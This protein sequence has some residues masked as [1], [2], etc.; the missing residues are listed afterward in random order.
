MDKSRPTTP[1]MLDDLA[2]RTS[3]LAQAQALAAAADRLRTPS[4][5]L[6][7]TRMSMP[8]LRN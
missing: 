2:A 6:G 5:A 3:S 4:A 7:R 1:E 8:F